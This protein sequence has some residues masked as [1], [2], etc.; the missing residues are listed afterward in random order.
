MYRKKV[1]ACTGTV[2]DG[3]SLYE[4]LPDTAC[5]NKIVIKIDESK[6][7]RMFSSGKFRKDWGIH[8]VV[9]YGNLREEIKDF[10]K[11]IGF[12]V[13]TPNPFSYKAK[14]VPL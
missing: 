8:P 3:N 5:R 9:F 10:A 2:L 1:F 13:M 12:D 11:L 6:T 14:Q 7:Y 4:H